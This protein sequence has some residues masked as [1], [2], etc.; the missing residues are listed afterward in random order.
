MPRSKELQAVID[1]N[2]CERLARELEYEE[3]LF[4]RAVARDSKSADAVGFDS[5]SLKTSESKEH[6]L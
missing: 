5:V 3:A 2:A 6:R 1:F 4:R